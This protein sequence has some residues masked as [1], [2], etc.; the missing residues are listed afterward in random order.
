MLHLPVYRPALLACKQR[1]LEL[2]VF[3]LRGPRSKSGYRRP[4]GSTPTTVPPS[5]SRLVHPAPAAFRKNDAT[6]AGTRSAW[7][8]LL[9]AP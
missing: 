2:R 8:I 7:S 5:Q 6:P 1:S 9:E 3:L 4:R